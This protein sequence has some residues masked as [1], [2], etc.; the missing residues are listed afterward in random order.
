MISSSPILVTGASGQVGGELAS[1][2]RL[3]NQPVLAPTSAEMNLAS[4]D[5]IRSYIRAHRPSCIVNAAAY[6]AVDKAESDM[7]TAEAV[8]AVAPGIL[9]EEAAALHIPVLHFST[10][11][12]FAGDGTKPWVESDATGPLNTYGRTKLQGE[13]ALAQSGAAYMVFRTSWVYGATGRNFFRTILRA[14]SQKDSL[15]IV[16]DQFGAPTWARDLA[17]L[18]LHVL[19]NAGADPESTIRDLSGRYHACNGGETTWF[20]FAEEILRNAAHYQPDIP[21]ATLHPVPTEA[22]PT[23]AKRPANSRMDCSLLAT[24]VGFRM[25][26]WRDSLAQVS[27]EY[28]QLRETGSL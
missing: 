10:D 28:N 13:D 6:T 26:E 20:G 25:P 5:A 23:P 8:N 22:Y 16:A 17:R 14:A 9:G 11:Y 4:P 24:K 12:V 18:V 21:F 3:R 2:L 7:E 15:T 27:R 19:D 1:L